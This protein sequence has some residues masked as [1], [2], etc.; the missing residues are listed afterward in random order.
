[1]ATNAAVQ[2]T[3]GET[4]ISLIRRFSKRVQ[5]AGVISRMRGRRYFARVKSRSVERKQALKRIS[6]RVH[7]EELIKLGKIIEAPKRRGGRR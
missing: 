2:K 7:I 4:T 5:G 1:M 6:R 3:D